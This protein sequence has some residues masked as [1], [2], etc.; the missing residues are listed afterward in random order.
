MLQKLRLDDVLFACEASRGNI[1]EAATRLGVV[2]QS[3]HRY[4]TR[5]PKARDA[6][7]QWRE[8]LVD[9]AESKMWEA[10]ESGASWAISLILRTQGRGRGWSE[11]PTVPVDRPDGLRVY[12]PVKG[13]I[14]APITLYPPHEDAA[15]E[16]VRVDLQWG[17]EAAHQARERVAAK[18]NQMARREDQASVL[19]VPATSTTAADAP[20]EEDAALQTRLEELI[21]Q[22]EAMLRQRT[23]R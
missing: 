21:T 17:D 22:A 23:D 8:R 3:L 18:L 6:F 15:P 9:L 16:P 5:T 4:L 20:E 10:V 1:T 14:A 2:R 12:L 19:A 13:S 7:D 11:S